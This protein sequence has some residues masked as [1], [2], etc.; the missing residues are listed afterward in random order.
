MKKIVTLFLTCALFGTLS[1]QQLSPLTTTGDFLK[2]YNPAQIS[3]NYFLFENTTSFEMNY[4]TQWLGLEG[5]PVTQSLTYQSLF[6]TK[7]AFSL[8]F[9]GRLVNDQTGPTGMFGGYLNV[10]A[11][12]TEEP[13]YGAWSLGLSF[14]AVQ[15]R[16]NTADFKPRHA[17]DILVFNTKKSTYP[18]VGFGGSWYKKMR[19]NFFN[20]GYVWAGISA[21]QLITSNVTFENGGA[22]EFSIN[23]LPHIVAFAGFQK[24]FTKSSMVQP[25]L[26]IR[27][28]NA[29][30]VNLDFNVKYMMPN[31]FWVGLG[32]SSSRS[33]LTEVG[34]IL[35]ENI[36]I[37]QEVRVAYH[38]GYS[39]K[40]YGA[41]IGNI[42]EFQ[43]SYS[44]E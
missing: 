9:G 30:P 35:G 37:D 32:A 13:Y 17:G 15:Y 38:F 33:L 4:R 36:G 43:A 19:N 25:T 8:L 12:F 3:E 2:S 29:A 21:P 10:A 1:G 28:V 7:N 24:Y 27:Y 22:G 20:D 16:V 40:D 41:S 18:D 23:R 26:A 31:T 34:M 11:M 39:M 44:F 14:G 42:H 6:E 5:A